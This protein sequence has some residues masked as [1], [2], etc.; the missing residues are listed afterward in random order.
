MTVNINKSTARGTISAPPSKSMAHRL[1]ISA[2][3]SEGTSKISGISDCD[4][5]EATI[6]CMRSLGVSIEKKG[7]DVFVTGVNMLSASPSE[8]L[9]C[10]E[11]GSTLRFI[12]PIALLSGKT[13]MMRGRE[14][15]MRRPMEIYRSLCEKKGLVYLSD[16]ESITVKGPLSGGE[17]SLP[18]NVSSQFISGLLFALPLASGNSKIKITPPVESRSYIEMTLAAIAL[19]GIDAS[20]ED[21]YTLSIKGGQSYSPRD[22]SVEGDYSGTAFPDALNLFGGSVDILGLNE[23][24]IQGD[25]VYKK[26]Y[27]QLLNGTPTIHIGDCPDLGPILFAVA[28]A[29]HGGVFTGT[30]RLKIKESDRATA[31]ADELKK[32]GVSVNVYDDKVVIYPAKFEK[33]SEKLFGHSDHRIV[34]ALSVLLTLTGGEIEGAEAIKKS[35]PAF[36]D[37]LKTLGIEVTRYEA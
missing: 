19:F 37:D 32:F 17:F 4:D 12:L 20:W 10:N 28:A 29:K 35:Y 34:M 14:G 13:V 27:E 26:Y 33:P 21:D 30:R 3:L 1:L 2:A 36:F 18:G 11:S 16:D 6:A 24:S 31:M 25:R 8:P 22:V 23:E 5:V 7:S 15:L 9:F